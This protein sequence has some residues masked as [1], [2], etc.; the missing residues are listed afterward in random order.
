MID[1]LYKRFRGSQPWKVV[2]AEG[3]AERARAD[4]QALVQ[5]AGPQRLML[6]RLAAFL[7]A[8]EKDPLRVLGHPPLGTDDPDVFRYSA[9]PQAS[10]SAIADLDLQRRELVVVLIKMKGAPHGRH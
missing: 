4:V 7:T 6:E 10:I 3:V 5:G 1:R 9:D 8:L 2:V